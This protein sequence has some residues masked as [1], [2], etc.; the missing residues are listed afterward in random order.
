MQRFLQCAILCFSLVFAASCSDDSQEALKLNNTIVAI[1]DS[2]F[3]KGKVWGDEFRIAFNTGNFSSLQPLRMD[4]QQ[5]VDSKLEVVNS[6]KDVGGSEEL[7][8]SEIDFLQF[9][10]Q[11]IS[12][13]MSR[14]ETFNDSTDSLTVQQSVSELLVISKT[15]QEKLDALRNLQYKYSQANDFELAGQK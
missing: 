3:A 4:M 12:T 9:E 5:F 13:T 11:A 7:R 10:K 15:E 6:M 14:F 2:L 1:N 8:R